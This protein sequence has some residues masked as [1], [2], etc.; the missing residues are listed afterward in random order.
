MKSTEERINYFTTESISGSHLLNMYT[1]DTMG[2]WLIFGETLNADFGGF[3]HRP[4]L[5]T[6]RGKLADVIE[7]AVDLPGFWSCGAGGDIEYVNMDIPLISK[8]TNAERRRLLAERDTL[9]I[10]LNE[11]D[12]KLK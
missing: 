9:Q 4:E 5:G 3:G 10:R 12:G 6:V 7:Y 2:A 1:L 11:I 8:E